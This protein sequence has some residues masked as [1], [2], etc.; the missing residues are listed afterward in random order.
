MSRTFYSDYVKHAL[1]FYTRFPRR[2]ATFNTDADRDNWTACDD[3]FKT[4]AYADKV[5]LFDVYSG[6]DTLADEVYNASKKHNLEQNV[7][8]EMMKAIEHKIAKTR[9]LI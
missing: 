3:V 7:I 6:R 8:W 1:R 5:I 9:G 2:P 4:Y